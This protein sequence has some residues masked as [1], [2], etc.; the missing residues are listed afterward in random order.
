[1]NARPWHDPA[2]ARLSVWSW[3]LSLL[4]HGVAVGAFIA[5]VADLRLAPQPEPFRWEVSLIQT[6]AAESGNSPAPAEVMP[7]LPPLASASPHRVELEAVTQPVQTAQPALQVAGQQ[8]VSQE[9]RPVPEAAAAQQPQVI[10]Q[11]VQAATTPMPT[12]ATATVEPIPLPAT[13]PALKE[14]LPSSEPSPVSPEPMASAPKPPV[15]EVHPSAPIEPADGPHPAPETAQA[16]AQA[17]APAAVEQ[18]VAKALSP[19]SPPSPRADYGWLA[20]ALWS[21]VEQ[22]KR[23][24]YKARMNRWEGRVVLR[25]VVMENGQIIDPTVAETSGHS[26]LDHE[27]LEILRQ[28]SPLKLKH[29]L[30]KPQI[31]VHIPISYKLER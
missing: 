12:S 3:V 26:L 30:G 10:A 16:P 28:A 18:V 8:E 9:S 14:T 5:L 17:E 20:E 1:M 22:L 21:R 19:Q 13:L 23:Y 11:A 6:P 25:V 31:V 7:A 29:P 4:L 24:P 15:A 2:A 27:A